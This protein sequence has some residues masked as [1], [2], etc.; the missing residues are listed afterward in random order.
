LYILINLKNTNKK[1]V[2]RTRSTQKVKNRK[3][4]EKIKV[5]IEIVKKNLN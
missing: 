3:I 4:K 1:R 5:R 2:K